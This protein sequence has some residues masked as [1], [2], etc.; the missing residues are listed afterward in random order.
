MCLDKKGTAKGLE[1]A[2]L[3]NNHGELSNNNGDST[4]T[5]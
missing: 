5:S 1:S 2:E 4:R 3:S